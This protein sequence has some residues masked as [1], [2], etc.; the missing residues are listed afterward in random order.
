MLA[1]LVSALRS[2]LPCAKRSSSKAFDI[3]IFQRVEDI[4]RKDWMD[5]MPNDIPYLSPDYLKVLT[6][7]TKENL[8]FL[9]GLAYHKG[10]PVVAIAFNM[11]D[12]SGNGLIPY[13]PGE[14]AEGFQSYF[15]RPFRYIVKGILNRL[16]W[17]VLLASNV[18]TPE[19]CS[20][21]YKDVNEK[22]AYQILSDMMCHIK[23]N[24]L[25]PGTQSISH[26]LITDIPRHREYGDKILRSK[27]FNRFASE[28]EMM[29]S[30]E[31]EW[32]SYQDY[33]SAITSK[34]RTKA[35]S[36][37]KKSKALEVRE[38]DYEFI[39]ENR[40]QIFQLYK[41][42]IDKAKFMISEV[43]AN[44]FTGLKKLYGPELKFNGYF[45]NDE[46]VAFVMGIPCEGK[47]DIHFIGLNYE[48]NL[49]HRIYQRMLYDDISFSIENGDRGVNFGRTATEIKSTLGAKPINKW[50]Y[51]K[52]LNPI[53]NLLQMPFYK[54]LKPA[55]WTERNPFK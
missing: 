26:F 10:S 37:L 24:K 3:E 43:T 40:E 21:Y 31:D 53:S 48:Y 1:E 14:N 17:R 13:I 46:L 42:V 47:M 25:H 12:W 50:N 18:I 29:L 19:S 8:N 4:P 11:V 30:F 28:P 36:V 5:V 15:Y 55:T 49:E 51:L 52:S 35:K 27:F 44:Y 16:N 6:E 45:L 39:N 20:F 32:T 54:F 7:S 41:N 23:I 38:L 2:Q 22:T 9:Y 34:Y 33:L